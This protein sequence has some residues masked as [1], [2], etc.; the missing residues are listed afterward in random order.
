MSTPSKEQNVFSE[1]LRLLSLSA[2]PARGFA[3]DAG[4][5]ENS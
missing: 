3:A 2:A 4:G 5:F 1:L